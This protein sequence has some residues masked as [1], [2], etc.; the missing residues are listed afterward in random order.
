MV[1]QKSKVGR[2]VSF[3]FKT[4]CK[5]EIKR[6]GHWRKGTEQKGQKENRF[7]QQR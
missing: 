2:P 3:Y 7:F 4:Y 5:A 6:A 1:R